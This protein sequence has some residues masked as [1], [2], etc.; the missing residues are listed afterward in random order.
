MDTSNDKVKE[1]LDK[2]KELLQKV[3]EVA[4]ENKATI[5]LAVAGYFFGEKLQENQELSGAL[6]GGLLG[7][8]ID[9][10]GKKKE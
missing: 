5:A 7:A 10:K 9:S 4:K 6:L 3:P 2:G 8:A 1:L